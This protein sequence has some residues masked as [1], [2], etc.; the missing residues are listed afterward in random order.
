MS[1]DTKPCHWGYICH[2]RGYILKHLL[3]L[4]FIMSWT[5][6]IISMDTL[7]CHWGTFTMSG[8]IL[9]TYVMA[10]FYHVRDDL[11]IVNG[12]I[13]MSSGDIVHVH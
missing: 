5:T 2:V 13:T 7:Q 10:Y 12:Y 11:Y 3:W 8:E 6:G 4:T 1:M 9:Q